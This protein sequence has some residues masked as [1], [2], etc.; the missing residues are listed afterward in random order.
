M[1]LGR[2]DRGESN[3]THFPVTELG[4]KPS[5]AFAFRKIPAKMRFE[6]IQLSAFGTIN[7][8]SDAENPQVNR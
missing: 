8:N 4:E 2:T 1:D 6:G 5:R 3:H 7:P